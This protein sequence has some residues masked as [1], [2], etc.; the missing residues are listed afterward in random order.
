ME[1]S[2]AIL[3]DGDNLSAAHA[4]DLRRIAEALGRPTVLRVYGD[5]SRALAWQAAPGFRLC[6]AGNGKNAADLL[7]TVEAMEL[8]LEH[9]FGALILASSDGDFSHLALRLRERGMTI[10]GAGE[11]KAPQH[12]RAACNRFLELGQAA[13]TPRPPAHCP[14]ELPAPTAERP[15]RPTPLDLQIRA[16]IA[17][18]SKQ[19][20]G[21]P[22]AA[23]S[24]MMHTA[25]G[26]RISTLPEKTWRSYLTARKTL[27]DLDPRGP[28][29]MV[30]FRPEGF[31]GN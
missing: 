28:G 5:F 10:V 15:D 31:A 1:D 26:V 24:P 13:P 25:H 11:A 27:Y 12:F 4:P 6:H 3:V 17:T 14:S 19:G 21:M 7:M 30:R 29:A 23:L 9:D 16:M 18:H 2:I 8:A 20:R 22:L